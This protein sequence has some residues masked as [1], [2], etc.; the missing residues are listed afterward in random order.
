M[1][2]KQELKE[3]IQEAAI[4]VG[5]SAMGV[6]RSRNLSEHDAHFQAWLNKGF[7][8]SMAYLERNLD[9]R[10]DPGKIMDNTKS[11]FVFLHPYL[12]PETLMPILPGRKISRYAQGAD[13]HSIIKDKLHLIAG[14]YLS[15]K[16]RIFTDSAPVLERA[17]AV[18]AGLGWIGK[19]SLLLNRTLGSYFFIGII[20]SDME[21]VPDTS[22]STN[23]CGTCRA[24]MDACPTQAIVEPGVV[25]GSACISYA[26]IEN[27]EL[28]ITERVVGNTEGWVF[29]CDICQEVCPWN[30]FAKLSHDPAFDPL[31]I[32]REFMLGRVNLETKED[33]ESLEKSPISR[34]GNE[35]M[36]RNIRATQAPKA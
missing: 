7:Q 16:Y 36:Q 23:H 29:G 1:P 27:K 19:N 3:I 17:W 20:L 33:W 34:A 21:F 11:V 13:Y 18:E 28:E 9:K 32:I 8:G 35:M 5:F 12:R 4:E 14:K 25:N 31:P 26:T 24:C 10:L 30:R 2:L 15:G 6:A 22:L